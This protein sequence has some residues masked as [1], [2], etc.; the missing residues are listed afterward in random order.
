MSTAELLARVPEVFRN[1]I[2]AGYLRLTE[3][4]VKIS[5]KSSPTNKDET[6]QYPKLEALTAEGMAILC[7]GKIE[8]A[9]SAPDEGKD[10]R[11][12]DQKKAG[13][14]DYFN[15]GYDLTVRAKERA[16][17]ESA[18]EGPEKAIKKAVDALVANAGFTADEARA[19]VI[20]Q[21]QKQGLPV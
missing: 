16:A 14:C 6:R 8:P 3:G 15:Y 1:A 5:A 4:E 17:L 19:M 21:R 13:A 18:L 11:T 2:T 12:E 20:A 10:E 9:T 7:G